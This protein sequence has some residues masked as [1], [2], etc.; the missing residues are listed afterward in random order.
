MGAG[1]H[2]LGLPFHPAFPTQQEGF[3][4][5]QEPGAAARP[6]QGYSPPLGS[7]IP[8]PVGLDPHPAPELCPNPTGKAPAALPHQAEMG[9][10]K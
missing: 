8:V 9:D 4:H 2:S 3:E 5:P 1:S 6:E 10:A 7:F